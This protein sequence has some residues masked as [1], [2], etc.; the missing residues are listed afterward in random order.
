MKHGKDKFH[1]VLLLMVL[2]QA[3]SVLAQD[4]K[5]ALDLVQVANQNGFRL[6][7]RTVQVLTDGSRS[8]VR[9]DEKPN[10]NEGVAWLPN[11]VF[12]QGTIE[13]DMR[14]KDVLQ[15]SFVGI[16]F[17][18]SSE[19]N[20]DAIYFRPFNFRSA[21]PVRRVHAVQ[22]ISLPKHDW[23]VLRKEFPDHYEKGIDPAPDP[24]DWFHARIVVA[25]ETIQVFVNGN[26][27]PS[28]TVKKLS[29]RQ[30]GN[31]GLWVGASSGGDFANLK[32]TP[33]QS[34]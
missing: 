11:T 12:S 15:R 17:H 18:G 27:T 19:R 34:R 2:L 5:A 8:G 1:L 24:N 26:P 33:K 14:G 20:Y 4:E 10:A 6:E 21:D 30:E 31:I 23:P 25:N 22:Y 3:S 7:N 28:L 9:L 32:I 13:V 29:D 16:A